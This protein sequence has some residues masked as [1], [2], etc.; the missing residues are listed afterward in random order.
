VIGLALLR[1]G[2]KMPVFNNFLNTSIT[3]AAIMDSIASRIQRQAEQLP[4]VLNAGGGAIVVEITVAPRDQHDPPRAVN[5][6]LGVV[7]NWL[8]VHYQGGSVTTGRTYD[9]LPFHG[10]YVTEDGEVV[11]C[12]SVAHGKIATLRRIRMTNPEEYAS[13]AADDLPGGADCGYAAYQGAVVFVVRDEKDYNLMEVYVAV[14]GSPYDEEDLAL[15]LGARSVLEETLVGQFDCQ[16]IGAEMPIPK[17]GHEP[18]PE[19]RGYSEP[20]QTPKPASDHPVS[21]IRF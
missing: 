8:G 12:E 14:S 10:H 3:P 20:I 21:R 6:T 5:A 17:L 18:T 7:N 2:E 19:P 9:L 11:D 1:G 4:N 13:Y 16:L 15:A